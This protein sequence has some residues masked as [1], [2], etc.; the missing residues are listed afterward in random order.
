MGMDRGGGDGHEEV[1][2]GHEEV[3]GDTEEQRADQS[4]K[5]TRTAPRGDFS[6]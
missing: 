2:G 3:A 1:A 6:V 4:R 5:A